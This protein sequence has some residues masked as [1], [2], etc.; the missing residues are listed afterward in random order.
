MSKI[1]FSDH[2][3]PQDFLRQHW[4][5]Q[6]VLLP[7]FI[8]EFKELISPQ[9]LAGLACEEMVESRL[10]VA[11]E[12][13]S[14]ELEHG[15]FKPGR[16]DDL[17]ESKWSLLVQAVDQWSEKVAAIKPL[18]NFIPSWRI[19]DVMVSYATAGGGVGPHFDYYDVFLLQGQ[20]QRRWQVGK[21]CAPDSVLMQHT[22]LGI[23]ASFEP[24]DE[25]ILNK[26]DALYLPPQFAHWGVSQ[27]NSLCYSIGFRAPALAEMLEGFSDT[28]IAAADPAQRY[29]D[30]RPE[31]PGKTGQI[32]LQSL[33]HAFQT[34]LGTFSSE[35]KFATWFGCYVT[36]PK[37]PELIQPLS[38]AL[39]EPE[40]TARLEA[41]ARL[42]RN[43]SSRFAFLELS[44]ASG[45]LFFADGSV[46]TLSLEVVTV[47]SRLCDLTVLKHE[48]ISELI[49]LAGMSE[50]VLELVNQGS[51][52][53]A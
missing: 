49:G 23:L 29:T 21:H 40:L 37:Y 7:G 17:P 4:Q 32:E 6:P 3:K 53:V 42:L 44:D 30:Y 36:Q 39:A 19:E 26:G 31:I 33:R 50:L 2:F 41:G 27:G 16:F 24:V 51:L 10:V 8:P 13:E 48:A 18:F 20:G 5:K 15:P 38:N 12:E 34:L 25:F 14:W 52:L 11:A 47:I 1:Q 22:D 35:A 43:P 46:H 45:L 9:E 28:L